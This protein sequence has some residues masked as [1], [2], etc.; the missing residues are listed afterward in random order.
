MNSPALPLVRGLYGLRPGLTV[1]Q[2][3][4][5][6]QALEAAGA[7]ADAVVG[8]HPRKANGQAG[9][10]AHG[11]KQGQVS[12]PTRLVRVNAAEGHSR[13]VVDGHMDIFPP[14]RQ[15]CSAGDPPLPRAL[16]APQLLD[17]QMQEIP[18]RVVLVAVVGSCQ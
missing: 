17:V 14:P 3:Q 16:E 7:I 4:S 15:A 18:G 13:V 11:P 5:P 10:V 8:E 6:A 1:F 12:T 9:V 2:S